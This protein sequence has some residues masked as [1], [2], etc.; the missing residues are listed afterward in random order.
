ME[1]YINKLI[2]TIANK[3]FQKLRLKL[4]IIAFF[5]FLFSTMVFAAEWKL[6]HID[7]GQGTQ[8]DTYYYISS[9]TITRVSQN[10]VRF[11]YLIESLPQGSVEPSKEELKQKGFKNYIEIECTK[12]RYRSVKHEIEPRDGYMIVTPIQWENIEPDSAYEK[13]ADATCRK[14]GG[15]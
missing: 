9:E 5:C 4:I 3:N 11:W 6:V 12:K 2:R 7:K 1:P 8:Y 15:N 14:K 10:K 13:M